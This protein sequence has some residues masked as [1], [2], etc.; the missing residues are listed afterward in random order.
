MHGQQ[1][2]KMFIQVKRTGSQLVMFQAPLKMN[3]CNV[4]SIFIFKVLKYML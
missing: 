4:I 2:I 1:N 3:L